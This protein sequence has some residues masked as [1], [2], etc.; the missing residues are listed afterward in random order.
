MYWFTCVFGIH[1]PWFMEHSL[2]SGAKFLSLIKV[3]FVPSKGPRII[4]LNI[5]WMNIWVLSHCNLNSHTNP[6][7]CFYYNPISLLTNCKML[8]CVAFDPTNICDFQRGS[9]SH[10]TDEELEVRDKRAGHKFHRKWQTLVLGPVLLWS[11]P[12]IFTAVIC[13]WVNTDQKFTLPFGPPTKRMFWV[14]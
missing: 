5:G 2:K 14:S 12:V 9:Q 6:V 10:F 3:D 13:S 7:I 11:S 8:L 4:S 1:L